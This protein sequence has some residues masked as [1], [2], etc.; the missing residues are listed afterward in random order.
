MSFSP[1]SSSFTLTSTNDTTPH[2]GAP[3]IAA[4]NTVFYAKSAACG[5][6]YEVKCTGSA[7]L[8]NAC[9]NGSVI[10]EVT[11]QC[12]CAGNAQ[13]VPT[14]RRSSISS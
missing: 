13:Y 14:T 12:P 5:Q 1:L 6:C 10:V 3:G 2:D 11:D 8:A 7:Y 4:A 9:V